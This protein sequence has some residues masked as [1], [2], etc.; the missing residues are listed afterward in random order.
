VLRIK[1]VNLGLLDAPKSAGFRGH[2][3]PSGTVLLNEDPVEFLGPMKV[4]IIKRAVILSVFVVRR[5]Y[6]LMEL[7]VTAVKLDV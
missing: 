2:V 7:V 6:R 5:D 3:E 1:K 4:L